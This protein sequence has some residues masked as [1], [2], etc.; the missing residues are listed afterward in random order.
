M[1]AKARSWWIQL[2]NSSASIPEMG[3]HLISAI[4][5]SD[6]SPNLEI[7]LDNGRLTNQPHDGHSLVTA[8]DSNRVWTVHTLKPVY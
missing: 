1:T 5:L 6:P 2:R 4:A 8:R 3:R 7:Q